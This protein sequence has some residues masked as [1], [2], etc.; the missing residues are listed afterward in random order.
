MTAYA[1]EI[2]GPPPMET[3]APLPSVILRGDSLFV[4][5]VCN[6]SDFPGWE[7]GASLDH[8]GFEVYCAV[9][10]FTGVTWHHFGSPNDERLY[11]HP[12]Y[13][14]GLTFYGY[15]EVHDSERTEGTDLHHWIITFHDETLEVTGKQMKVLAERVATERPEEALQQISEQPGAANSATKRPRS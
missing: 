13:G 15:H 7:S 2:H 10:V 9:I 4:A 12:L 5:Y 3:G 6:N 1:K 8:H 14:H 11:E